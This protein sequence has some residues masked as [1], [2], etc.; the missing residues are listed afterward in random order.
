MI[1]E[2]NQLKDCVCLS[3][4]RK[5]YQAF[6]RTGIHALFGLVLCLV[7]SF[8]SIAAD[9]PCGFTD[10]LVYDGL[11][12]PL[13]VTFLPD[14]RALA[15]SK[16]GEIVIFNPNNSPISDPA[17]YMTL[18]VDKVSTIA[19]S[20]LIDLALDLNFTLDPNPT[21]NQNHY[22]YVYYTHEIEA[23]HTTELPRISRFEHNVA[24]STGDLNSETV[25]FINTDAENESLI[26]DDPKNH[27]NH[28]GAGLDFAPDGSL[29]LIVGDSDAT[30]GTLGFSQDL[31]LYAGKILRINKDGTIPADNPNIP[32]ALPEI[33][34]YG[35][36][37]PFRARFDDPTGRLFIGD[38]G[39]NTQSIAVEEVNLA[40]ITGADNTAGVN[41]GWSICEGK[42]CMDPPGEPSS[43]AP[44]LFSYDHLGNQASITGGI[45][46][47]GTVFPAIYNGAYFYGDFAR[48]WLRYLTFDADGSVIGNFE[49]SPN[50]GS[51]IGI[52]QSPAGDLYYM[53]R[54]APSEIRRIRF[55]PT[56]AAPKVTIELPEDG[57][58]FLEN[59]S[60]TF[61]GSAT[62]CDLLDSDL[63]GSLTWVSDLAGSIGTGATFVRSG[64]TPWRSH[65]YLYG[66]R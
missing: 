22:F 34:A 14:G 35:L 30:D 27:F 28:V 32:G 12:T 9:V 33:F 5:Y 48:G 31:S 63:T 18:P 50:V 59:E 36:R 49:L 1:L 56:S 55:S 66:Y 54:G 6:K 10:E 39:G 2:R 37:N 26:G 41:Y 16:F 23:P 13:G 61:T 44:P 62:A 7:P 38:V 40:V 3:R 42:T 47:R 43:H 17:P 45:V 57:T 46:Y 65:H 52:E 58:S 21:G 24:T 20:G 8:K 15:W 19:E 60:I 4:E 64:L 25:L 51:V 53:T 11:D 29:I